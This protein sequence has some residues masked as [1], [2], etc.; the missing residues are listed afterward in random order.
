MNWIQSHKI[1]K[2]NEHY[3]NREFTIAN[4]NQYLYSSM[5]YMLARI[6]LSVVLRRIS[7]NKVLYALPLSL[8]TTEALRL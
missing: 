7:S 3:T 2:Q 6:V 8:F 5:L 4:D 1:I